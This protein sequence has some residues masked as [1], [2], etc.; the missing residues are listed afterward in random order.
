MNC[1]VTLPFSGLKSQLDF[2]RSLLPSNQSLKILSEVH[3]QKIEE[4]RAYSGYRKLP[5]PPLVSILLSQCKDLSDIPIKLKQLREDYT[6]LRNSFTKLERKIDTAENL[7]EQ[8]NAVDELKG[9]W[10]VFNKKYIG[11]NNRLMHH[12][13]DVKN[14]SDIDKAAE[15]VLDSGVVEDFTSNLN[16]VSLLSKLAGKSYSFYRDKKSLNRFKGMTN[17]WE[18]FQKTPTLENQVK[19]YERIFKVKIDLKELNRLYQKTRS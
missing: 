2:N 12:F 1:N 14:A 17:I 11:S 9:F 19:D 5:I 16:V 3:N 18:L 13:W 7:K 10:K 6:E 8:M 4:L 15:K